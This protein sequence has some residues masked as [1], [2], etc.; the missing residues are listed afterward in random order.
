M[1]NL[2]QLQDELSDSELRAQKLWKKTRDIK[3]LMKLRE[4]FM[5]IARIRK[6]ILDN[7]VSQ[8]Q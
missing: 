2:K 3:K 7:S 4:I 8:Q 5:T 6:E 1:I